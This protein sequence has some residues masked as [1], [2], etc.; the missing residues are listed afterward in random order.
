ME[1]FVI[2]NGFDI[3]HGLPTRYTNFIEYM[4]K[5]FPQEYQWLYNS[6]KK[7]SLDYWDIIG[8]ERD[9]IVWNDMEN[10]LGSFEPLELLEEQRDWNSP[11][12]QLEN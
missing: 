10:V 11:I 12:I 5:Y 3:Y 1:L 7:Y 4:K 2:G 8:K 9:K 6:I